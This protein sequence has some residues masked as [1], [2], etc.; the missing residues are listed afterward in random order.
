MPGITYESLQPIIKSQTRE[1]MYVKC[2]FRCPETGVEAEGRGYLDRQDT[3]AAQTKKAVKRSLWYSLRRSVSSALGRVVGGG[4]AGSAARN[5]AHGAMSGAESQASISEKD[6]QKGVVRAFEQVQNK[7]QWDEGGG[8]WVGTASAGTSSMDFE[9]QLASHP[10]RERYD[11]GIL[12]RMLVEVACADGNVADEERELLGGFIPADIGTVD[13][14]A[15]RPKLSGMELGE[16]G[17]SQVRETMLMLGWAVALSDE[18]LADVERR[19]LG[20]VAEGFGVAPARV[21]GLRGLAT[22]FL[23]QQAIAAG[24]PGGQR[25]ADVHADAMAFAAKLGM[26]HEDAQKADITYRKKMGIV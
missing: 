8:K 5:V 23:F 6:I 17:D 4:I 7:Y 10:V 12:A 20:E 19:R 1:G 22:G 9:G 14:L 3:V 25:D 2:V 24:Y 11:Q 26:S 16:V 15:T 18:D 21:E 13:D